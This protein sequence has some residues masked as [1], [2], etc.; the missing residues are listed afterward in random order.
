MPIVVIV[1]MAAIL[2]KLIVRC[3]GNNAQVIHWL[4]FNVFK[5]F[6]EFIF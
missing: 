6:V 1:R 3:L 2:S 4:L 5:I